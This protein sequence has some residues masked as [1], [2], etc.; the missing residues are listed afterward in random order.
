MLGASQPFG[1]G[2]AGS[3][4]VYLAEELRQ[5]PGSSIRGDLTRIVP[6]VHL[7]SCKR[8]TETTLLGTEGNGCG[9]QLTYSVA[10]PALGS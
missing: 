7:V 6:S 3:G 4:G 9:Q 5:E 1:F 8:C 10:L 2:Q